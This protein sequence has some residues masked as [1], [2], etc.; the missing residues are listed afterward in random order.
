MHRRAQFLDGLKQLALAAGLLTLVATSC[1]APPQTGTGEGSE[2]SVA[3]S[4][5]PTTPLPTPTLAAGVTVAPPLRELA[6]VGTPTAT[7]PPTVTPSPT[8][9]LAP[10]E[11]LALGQ[12]QLEHEDF[13]AAAGIFESSLSQ[14]GS[15]TRE[16]QS[17]ALWGLGQ[18]YLRHERYAEAEET[19]Q[20]YQALTMAAATATPEVAERQQGPDLSATTAQS[21]PG[22]VPGATIFFFQGQAQEGQQKCDEAI[23]SY[24]AYLEANPDMAAYVQPLIAH[25]ALQMGNPDLAVSAYE[26]AIQAGAHRLTEIENRQQLADYYL[27]VERYEDAVAQYDAIRD[28]AETENT[29]GEMTYLAGSALIRAG[30]EQAGYERYLF[31][32]NNYPRAYESYLGLVELIDASVEVPLY[33]RGLVDYYAGAYQPAVAA[34]EEYLATNPADYTAEAHLYLAWSYEALGNSEAVLAQFDRF[35]AAG[36]GENAARALAEKA[37]YYDRA[38]MSDAAL[39]TYIELRTSYPASAQAAEATWQAALLQ[40]ARGAPDEALSLYWALVE[41]YPAHEQVPRALFRAGLR[42][43]QAGEMARATEIWQRLAAAYPAADYGAAAIIWLLRTAPDEARTTYEMT[44]TAMTGVSYYPLR[45]QEVVRG[46]SPFTPLAELQ[47]DA[48]EERETREAEDWLRAQLG[49]E[50]D[51]S[52]S[53]LTPVV[54]DDARLV[55]GQKLWQLDMFEAAR[56]ELEAVRAA[57]ADDPLT[58]Y[59]LALHFRELGL[60]RSA[61]L[62]AERL[63]ALTETSV[64]DAPRLIARLSYPIHYQE[65]VLP[66]AERYGYDPLLQFALIRQ[67]SLFESFVVSFAGAQGLS[68]VM[69]GT[70]EDIARQLGWHDYENEDLYRPYVGLEFGAYYLSQQLKAFDGNVYAALSAYNGGPGNAARWYSAAGDDPDLYLETVDFRETR[71]YIQRIYTGY[72]VYQHLYG[73]R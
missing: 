71:A 46:E 18:A 59:Q 68:Q 72:A 20:R 1:T 47:L 9:T 66:L 30:Q 10:S 23:A 14:P 62:A 50:E 64:F 21:L 37:A 63:L 8:A 73:R 15:L 69:P 6:R 57:Y 11:L 24:R 38:G 34:F 28:L 48:D 33:Q 67:E 44:A 39:A 12:Q 70:G 43:W 31:G 49:L 65:I 2:G 4:S 45:A 40:D 61:I 13:S 7:A 53:Y 26:T 42:E 56:R 3:L 32:V 51:A 27:E 5:A 29:R 17:E 55:R 60:Y 22:V 52:L 54:R 58:T 35:A 41:Q 16:Q 19:L 25:C 36:A